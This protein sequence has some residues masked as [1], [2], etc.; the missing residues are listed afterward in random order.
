MN[1][2]NVIVWFRNDLRL[3]DNESLHDA[4]KLSTNVIPVYVFDTRIFRG[5]LK[6]GAR[7]TAVHRAK[8]IVESVTALRESLKA[9]GADLI[10]RVGYPEEIVAQ[11][12]KEY[13]T[14]WVFCNRERTQEEILV[15]DRLEKNLWTNGQELRQS[16]GKML[17][18]TSDLPFPVPHTPDTFTQFRKEVEKITPIR[19]PLPTPD[20]V[21]H[22]L[23]DIDYGEIPSLVDLGYETPS[24]Q[25]SSFLLGGEMSGLSRLQFYFWE[26]HGVAKYKETRNGLLGLDCSSKFSAYL[27]TGCLSPK[28]IYRE[29]EK[30]ERT[31]GA[32]ESTYHLFFELLW[33][34]FFRLTGKKY[35]NVIFQVN[36]TKGEP[37]AKKSSED[38]CLFRIWAEGR[39]GVPLIDAAMRE[40]VSTGFMSNRARQN[41][42]SFLVHDME[43]NW[44]MGAEFF[45]SYLIDYDPC[46]NWGNWNYIAGVGSD[47]RENRWFN[48]VNQ[49]LRYDPEARYIKHW[50][51]MLR[52]L[53]QEYVHAPFMMSTNEQKKYEFM[54]GKDYP[55]CVVPDFADKVA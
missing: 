6:F 46:S 9:R 3:H 50:L 23:N 14:N 15:Q 55:D 48:V 17:Y 13:K 18:Y 49:S 26:S 7:K 37:R 51:P 10:V 4:V 27:S 35:G 8:F 5:K 36:G 43:L 42:A 54:L 2:C 41:A 38:P 44:Q 33:R 19:P 47:P 45:E 20:Q 39:T 30:Y 53:P 52:K 12:A 1:Q 34:D 25:Q 24:E 31:Q 11:L 16:R 32:N 28:F 29:L 21:P 40:L 22:H